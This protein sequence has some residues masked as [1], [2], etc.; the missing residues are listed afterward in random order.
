MN[1]LNYNLYIFCTTQTQVKNFNEILRSKK[2]DQN[3][4]STSKEIYIKRLPEPSCHRAKMWFLNINF[5]RDHDIEQEKEG[6]DDV[7]VNFVTR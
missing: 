3:F 2:E 1:L 6:L 5:E 4:C 7:S